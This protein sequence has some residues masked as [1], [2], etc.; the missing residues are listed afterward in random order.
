MFRFEFFCEDKHVAPLMIAMQ[1]K[2]IGHPLVTP[3]A[4][5]RIGANGQIEAVVQGDSLDMFRHFIAENK[6]TEITAKDAK[7]FVTS[8]GYAETG[9]SAMLTRAVKA[10]FLKKQ[11]SGA[12]MKY[13]VTMEQPKKGAKK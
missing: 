2:T 11:G 3:V 10:G 8:I 4:N 5:A 13:R 6:L 12:G 7:R 9:Y 1:G